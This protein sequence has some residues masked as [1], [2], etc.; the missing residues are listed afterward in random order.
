[1]K[2]ILLHR[3][4]D[5]EFNPS[6]SIQESIDSLNKSYSRAKQTIERMHLGDEITFQESMD[7]EFQ[8]Y[9][10]NIQFLKE[11]QMIDEK[12][13]MFALRKE[14]IDIFGVD[15]WDDVSFNYEFNTLEEFYELYKSYVRN[16]HD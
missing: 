14:L 9:G 7:R 15:V 4:Q 6:P 3:I 1:M 10:R 5:G 12:K 13:K 8:Y 2:K 11:K 16:S